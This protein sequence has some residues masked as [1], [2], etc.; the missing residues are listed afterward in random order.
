MAAVFCCSGIPC[1]YDLGLSDV[2]SPVFQPHLRRNVHPR[3]TSYASFASEHSEAQSETEGIGV[4]TWVR[5]W[6]DWRGGPF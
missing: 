2:I 5:L 1:H 4:F 6:E 3:E